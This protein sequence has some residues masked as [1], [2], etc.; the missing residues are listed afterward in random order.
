[1][2]NKTIAYENIGLNET[3]TK[4]MLFVADNEAG[5]EA[6][7][8][9]LVA[10]LPANYTATKL[11]LASYVNPLD[12]RRDILENIN[13]GALM[14]NYAGH[15]GPKIWAQEEI[16]RNEDV[17]GLTNQLKYPF[18]VTLN[19][20]NGYFI[21]PVG[22]ECL[23]EELL[24]AQD[25]GAVAVFAP[26]GM[27][28]PEHQRI[29]AEGLFDSLFKQEERILGSA[30]ANAK[31][32]LFQEAG[33]SVPDVVQ[34]F[35]LFGDPA[36]ILRKEAPTTASTQASPSVYTST[37]SIQPLY[38]F[39]ISPDITQRLPSMLFATRGGWEILQEGKQKGQ[40]A[41]VTTQEASVSELTSA[42]KR[43]ISAQKE[44]KGQP[45]EEYQVESK[46]VKLGPAR[47]YRSRIQERK[48]VLAKAKLAKEAALKK[49][50]PKAGA[51]GSGFWGAIKEIVN[52]VAKFFSGR[53]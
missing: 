15:G 5:F 2:V 7:D 53:L 6:M 1:M 30:I 16:L 23:A 11:Y 13:Q 26:A 17:A 46:I 27:S 39:I 29:L 18:I 10:N 28:L 8:D 3:W 37:R 45:T 25:K 4:K 43:I 32:Y 24:R 22:L 47:Q 48:L 42:A 20:V 12:C 38:A 51:K 50:K 52:K 19:C 44:T 34:T 35:N 49:A 9:E 41:E 36:L 40:A 31:L 21:P 33:S 14:V